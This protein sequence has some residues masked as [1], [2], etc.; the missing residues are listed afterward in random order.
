MYC[1][2]FNA[3]KMIVFLSI[4]VIPFCVTKALYYFGQIHFMESHQG[5]VNCIERNIRQSFFNP[6]IKQFNIRMVI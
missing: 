4:I 1:A 3:D 6:V 5:P 2:A